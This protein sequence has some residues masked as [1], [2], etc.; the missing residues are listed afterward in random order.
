MFF[1]LLAYLLFVLLILN[2]LLE[3]SFRIFNRLQIREA[4]SAIVP[5]L[6]IAPIKWRP[7]RRVSLLVRHL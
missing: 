4:V 1:N 3:I 5:N 7:F 6:L 2:N